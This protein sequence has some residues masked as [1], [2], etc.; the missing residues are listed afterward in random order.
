MILFV[1]EPSPVLRVKNFT[2]EHNV[3]N[4]TKQLHWPDKHLAGVSLLDR[5]GVIKLYAKQNLC[6]K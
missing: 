4:P 6:S 5:I 2:H 3:L 1:T